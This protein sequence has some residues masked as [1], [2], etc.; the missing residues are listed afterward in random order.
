MIVDTMVLAYALLGVE[1]YREQA[2]NALDRS[3]ILEAPDS[4]KAELTNVVWQWIVR[5]GVSFHLGREVL[6]NSISIV[7][8]YIPV[9]VCWERAL[10]LAVEKNHPAY[11]TLFIAAAEYSGTVCLTS[12]TKLIETF[13]D[14][15][16]GLEKL[17]NYG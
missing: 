14:Q 6:W 1:G 5:R 10:V 13:P 12:D 17:S 2:A 8:R 3:N 9:E 4:L 15:T 11:D 7:D 16:I